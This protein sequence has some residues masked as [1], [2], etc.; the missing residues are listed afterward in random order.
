MVADR[1]IVRDRCMR[2]RRCV[3]DIRP[4]S[5]SRRTVSWADGVEPVSKFE[6]KAMRVKKQSTR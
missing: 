1:E 2:I 4:V 3:G 5:Q 6:Q